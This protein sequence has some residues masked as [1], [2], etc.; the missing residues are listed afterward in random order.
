MAETEPLTPGE[1]AD[2]LA[3]LED[4][5]VPERMARRAVNRWIEESRR[6]RPRGRWATVLSFPGLRPA[7]A[8]AAAAALVVVIRGRLGDEAAPPI[9]TPKAAER[10]E[11][12]DA[13]TLQNTTAQKAQGEK[14]E[15]RGKRLEERAEAK[16]AAGPGRAATAGSAPAPP[17]AGFA[18]RPAAPLAERDVAP[19]ARKV[20]AP[21]SAPVPAVSERMALRAARTPE[22]PSA[23]VA[24]LNRTEPLSRD[25]V[26]DS[27]VGDARLLQRI[28]LAEDEIALADLAGKIGATT[29]VSI[30]LSE[31]IAT[32]PLAVHC[33]DRPLREVMRQMGRALGIRWELSHQGDAIR[34]AARPI[35]EAEETRASDDAAARS[36]PA[37][38]GGGMMRAGRAPA[39]MQADSSKRRGVETRNIIGSPERV[40]ALRQGVAPPDAVQ[41]EGWIIVR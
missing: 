29:G 39:A 36:A 3:G 35:A 9:Q 24:Y 40:R 18:D 27:S 30:V 13:P 20:Q 6:E 17:A 34:Y 2:I 25:L 5:P 41:T 15:A 22:A 7:L 10:A 38:L 23:D 33:E 21:E 19:P 26:K 32:E 16:G 37:G 14:R 1:I 8:L 31:A 11:R 4:A 28:T 12:A